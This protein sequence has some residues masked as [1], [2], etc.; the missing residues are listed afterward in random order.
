MI[1]LNLSTWDEFQPEIT[2]LKRDLDAR[3][4][5][6]PHLPSK[7]LYRG[8]GDSSW[9]LTT[10]LERWS[11]REFDIESYHDF[12]W[13]AQ[14]EIESHIGSKYHVESP[15]EF[16]QWVS[17]DQSF[18][19]DRTKSLQYY[20]FLR[21]QGFPSPLLDWSASPYVAAFFA[22]RHQ[23]KSKNVSIFVFEEMPNVIKDAAHWKPGIQVLWHSG[24][25][26]PRHFA[27]M[28][29]YSACV[30][31]N[32]RI[33]KY[34]NH[35]SVFSEVREDQD[36]LYKINIPMSERN[37]ALEALFEIN[38]NAYTLFHSDDSIF[39]KIATEQAVIMARS[40]NQVSN[41]S[42][43]LLSDLS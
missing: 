38:I 9:S 36:I 35:E 17:G 34:C 42:F 21:H 8:Q 40:R 16:E 7:R 29:Y 20:M 32:D 18:F 24:A 6:K 22:F 11:D 14:F 28:S 13:R 41:N 33:R 1:E 12:A 30:V 25:A 5:L 26:H 27:Q 43:G 4:Q 39:E 10:T 23:T 2:K 31:T 3:L 37:K 15:E 19:I